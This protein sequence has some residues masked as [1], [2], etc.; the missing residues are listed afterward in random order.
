MTPMLWFIAGF[1]VAAQIACLIA[2]YENSRRS[3]WLDKLNPY[4]AD[5][6]ESW[7]HIASLSHAEGLAEGI[8]IGASGHGGDLRAVDE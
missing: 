3:Q 4:I 5:E 7:Q 2:L 1:V 6:R 8:Q